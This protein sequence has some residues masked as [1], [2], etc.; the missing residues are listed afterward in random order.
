MTE[1]KNIW[2]KRK[3]ENCWV[4]IECWVAE[5]NGVV[6]VEKWKDRKKREVE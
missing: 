3:S 2:Y 4:E 6:R 1:K 5:E